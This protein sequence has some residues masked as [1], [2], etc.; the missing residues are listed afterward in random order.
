MNLGM[1]VILAAAALL[2]SIATAGATDQNINITATVASFCKIA[3]STAPADD[4]I[5]W[6]PLI[7]NGDISATAS[8]KS[9]AV[10]CNKAT[11]ITLSSLNGAMTGPASAGAGWD[12]VINYT[13]AASGF[14]TVSGSTATNAA[15][16]GI[17][18]LGT[19][20]RATP[21]SANID[22]AITPVANAN[23][24]V[25]GVYSDTLRVTITP[26]P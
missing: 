10:V 21:G 9:Y 16:T 6:T 8:N 24:L 4:S 15:A 19:T 17:E 5:D 25:P 2:G 7:T 11:D 13:V 23:P 1:R 22:L 26:Q 3:G 18:T 14:A 12:N 20:T